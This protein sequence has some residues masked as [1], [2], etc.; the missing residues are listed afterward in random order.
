MSTI[1]ERR[2]RLIAGRVIRL[3]PDVVVDIGCEDGWIAESYVSQ[4]ERLWLADL[5]PEVLAAGSLAAHPKVRT[6]VSDATR[7]A[8]L[9]AALGSRGADVILLSALLE[10]LP[11]P[12]VAL[13]ELA[14]LLAPGGL[15]MLRR[16][17]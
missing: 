1:E 8:A 3:H 13:T 16:R 5:D 14:P 2:R 11:E 17:R 12:D 7:P 6:V 4:V 15:A 10:H 9:Q